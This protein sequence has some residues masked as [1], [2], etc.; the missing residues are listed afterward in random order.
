MRRALTL[1]EL[2]F[3]MVIIAIAFT[4]FPKILQVSAKSGSITL[5]EEA[6]YNAIALIGLIRALPWDEKNTQ[7]DDILV[8]DSGDVL[9]ECRYALGGGDSIY[10]RGGFIGAR[11]CQHKASASKIGGDSDD[12]DPDDIDD[13]NGMSKIATN[14]YGKRSYVM[15]VNISYVG[16]FKGEPIEFNTSPSTASTNVKFIK[17]SLYAQNLQKTLGKRLASFWYI[18]SNIGQLRINS[19]AW[20]H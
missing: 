13:F 5:K 6:M 19:M 18:S 2:I 12:S 10:R 14:I 17:V 3:S 8:T 9:Y 4:I 16:D 11:N 15:D 1:I 7:V 20:V